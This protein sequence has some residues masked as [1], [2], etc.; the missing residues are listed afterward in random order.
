MPLIDRF[1]DII[2]LS[3]TSAQYD[4]ARN[5]LL[6]LKWQF[7]ASLRVI[8]GGSHAS[9]LPEQVLEDGFDA[10]FAGEADTALVDWLHAGAGFKGII[11][12]KAPRDLD[13]LP[14]PARDLVNL[15][16]YCANLSTGKGEWATTV[17]MSR[18]CPY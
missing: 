16:S 10:V 12:C 7:G 14:V 9:A 3:V 2:A 15:Q 5:L 11:H 13:A 18:G 4:S 1:R 8:I 6:A 17:H